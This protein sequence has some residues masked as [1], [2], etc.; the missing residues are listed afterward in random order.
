[1]TK[2]VARPKALATLAALPTGSGP[3]GVMPPLLRKPIAVPLTEQQTRSHMAI[4]ST[5]TKNYSWNSGDGSKSAVSHLLVTT[6]E[7]DA[8]LITIKGFFTFLYNLCCV[9]S[10]RSI[11]KTNERSLLKELIF[12]AESSTQIKQ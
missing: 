8:D 9:R 4:I 6:K 2:S 12:R 10:A 1:M 5:S 3:I 11:K 7:V